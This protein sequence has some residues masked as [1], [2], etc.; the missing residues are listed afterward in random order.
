MLGPRP[1]DLTGE[2]PN[3]SFQPPAGT[4]VSLSGNELPSDVIFLIAED[5]AYSVYVHLITFA[6]NLF[7]I[8]TP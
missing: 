7:I 3:T 1:I 8:F 4:S 5:T 6:K 2:R